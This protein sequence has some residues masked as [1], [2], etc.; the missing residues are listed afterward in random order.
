MT[1]PAK[2]VLVSVNPNRSAFVL[3]VAFLSIVNSLA[4]LLP[5]ADQQSFWPLMPSTS[6]MRH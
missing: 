5:A 3:M 2:D 6:L 1:T 4:A